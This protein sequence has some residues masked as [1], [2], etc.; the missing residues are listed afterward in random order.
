MRNRD[1]ERDRNRMTLHFFMTILCD[2]LASNRYEYDAAITC[3][4]FKILSNS[5]TDL[6]LDRW[7]M[8]ENWFLHY[9]KILIRTI[10]CD[11]QVWIEL[12]ISM[13]CDETD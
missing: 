8:T 2:Y 4:S 12:E 6:S 5:G 10:L 1:L 3:D 9:H 13:K 7:A 11:V